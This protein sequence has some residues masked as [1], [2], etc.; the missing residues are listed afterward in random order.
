[1]ASEPE[2]DFTN[3][4]ATKAREIEQVLDIGVYP[5]RIIF[6]HTHKPAPTLVSEPI[7]RVPLRAKFGTLMEATWALLRRAQS[8]GLKVASQCLEAGAADPNA[9]IAVQQF[10]CVFNNGKA[11]G[12]DMHLL[13]IGGG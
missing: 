1:M 12:F 8:L 5:K 13:D 10:R 2:F 3:T 6:A 7:A 4:D 11:L 9:V